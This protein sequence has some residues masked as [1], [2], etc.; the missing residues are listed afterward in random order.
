MKLTMAGKAKEHFDI[1]EADRDT[2]EAAKSCEDL[3]SKVKD[4][5][6]RPKLDSS[7]KEKL[8]RGGGPVDV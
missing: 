3:L 4:Y 5:A 1:W 6:R 7:S 8:Q 2:T